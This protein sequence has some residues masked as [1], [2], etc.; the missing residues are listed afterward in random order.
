M[1]T[2]TIAGVWGIAM[3]TAG[4]AMAQDAAGATVL[5]VRLRVLD[6]AAI[7]PGVWKFAEADVATVYRKAGVTTAFQYEWTDMPAADRL[8]DV[9]VIAITGRASQVTA[10]SFGVASDAL[11]FV[12][13]AAGNQGRVVYVFDDRVWALSARSGIPYRELL[14][15]VLIHEIG[16]VL[17]PFK[18]HSVTGIMR[19][20]IDSTSRQLE[21]FT[22]SQARLMR[23]RLLSLQR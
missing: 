8:M 10:M 16:H 19:E 7:A 6:R 14:G 11:A 15:R 23:A 4:A 21:F 5:T 9:T 12:P 2:K 20:T 1:R 22:D 18:S 17:L 13:G 3:L